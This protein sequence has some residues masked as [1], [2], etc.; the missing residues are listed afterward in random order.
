M[1]ILFLKSARPKFLILEKKNDLFVAQIVLI[2]DFSVKI[3]NQLPRINRC[4]KFQ[5]N[6]IKDKDSRILTLKDIVKCSMT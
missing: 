4:T 6:W 3:R 5:P 1:A 2:S